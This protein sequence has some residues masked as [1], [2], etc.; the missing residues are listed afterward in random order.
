MHHVFVPFFIDVGSFLRRNLEG[1]GPQLEGQVDQRINHVASC[2]QVGRNNKNTKTPFSNSIDIQQATYAEWLTMFLTQV[3]STNI[4]DGTAGHFRHSDVSPMNL[5][6]SRKG[7]S[8]DVWESVHMISKVSNPSATPTPTPKQLAA[9]VEIQDT[10]QEIS[11]CMG[12]NSHTKKTTHPPSQDAL[13]INPPETYNAL[14][15]ARLPSMEIDFGI[16][17]LDGPCPGP[18]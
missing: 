6:L 18:F 1:C 5:Q 16:H 2:W 4:Q 10:K 11:F 9:K 13:A 14:M 3:A 7:Y 15:N 8:A 12:I 17:G